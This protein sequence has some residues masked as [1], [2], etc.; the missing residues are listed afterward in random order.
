MQRPGVVTAIAVYHAL[1]SCVLVGA[2]ALQCISHRPLDGWLYAAPVIAMLLFVSVIPA[3]F[4][5]GLW[6]MDDGAR[7]GCIMFTIL[8]LITTTFYVSH[9]P[10]ML[11][12]WLRI[13]LDVV[14][15]GVLMLPRIRLAFER[16][17]R[18][19]LDWNQPRA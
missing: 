14:I 6:M 1:F 11:R 12:P 17:S 3:V 5:V 2:L 19:L 18:L 9:S 15:I 16:E 7:I 10:N 8:H 4:C 13:V